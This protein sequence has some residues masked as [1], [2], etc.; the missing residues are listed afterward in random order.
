MCQYYDVTCIPEDKNRNDDDPDKRLILLVVSVQGVPLRQLKD[1]IEWVRQVQKSRKS[2]KSK[3]VASKI[4]ES[5]S[6]SESE[7]NKMKATQPEVQWHRHKSRQ[8]SHVSAAATTN[9][10]DD[11]DS[12]HR[13]TKQLYPHH[14]HVPTPGAPFQKKKRA[15]EFIEEEDES[16]ERVVMDKRI[17]RKDKKRVGLE[18][19]Q[20]LES[21]VRPRSP[22]QMSANTSQNQLKDSHY[23]SRATSW[24]DQSNN[25][26]PGPSKRARY[27]ENSQPQVK[28][29]KYDKQ[30]RE[31]KGSGSSKPLRVS[32]DLRMDDHKRRK[33][34]Q[35]YYVLSDNNEEEDS[36]D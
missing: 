25:Q 13:P 11:D 17:H 35:V 19:V 36:E 1:C 26:E 9:S 22:S 12:T 5:T 27:L 3:S 15:R 16:V 6:S 34:K 4:D 18:D 14:H 23:T 24:N 32:R 7:M 2:Q 21:H 8:H 28:S 30:E 31:V 10:D 33:F 20:H 29:R